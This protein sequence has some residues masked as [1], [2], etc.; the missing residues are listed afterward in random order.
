MAS[1]TACSIEAFDEA[2]GMV[3][4]LA[5]G[6]DGERKAS[7]ATLP[8]ATATAAEAE[9]S[10]AAARR[11]GAERTTAEA[12]R[13]TK[14]RQADEAEMLARAGAEAEERR[15]NERW[16]AESRAR[17]TELDRL[18]EKV[19]RAQKAKAASP[20]P[21][22]PPPGHSTETAAGQPAAAPAA[23]E[24]PVP[25]LPTA[26]PGLPGKPP[27]ARATIVL[28]MK[29]GTRGIRRFE[30]AADPLLCVHGGCY[31]STGAQAPATFEPGRRA[32]GI[33]N[34]WGARAGACNH[35]L[36]CV[37]RNVDL[38]ESGSI[39]QPVDMR[40]VH[41][42]WRERQAVTQDSDCRL[43]GASLECRR[44][45]RTEEYRLWIVAESL[46]EAAGP[47]AIERL[48]AMALAEMR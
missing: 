25:A 15:A 36:G 47:A 24:P 39:V 10:R 6:E 9:R 14:Q 37:F 35:S 48:L 20:A 45:I 5:G 7:P 32:L 29:P 41:H 46:A 12:Q 33:A 11:Q 19:R 26:G 8:P 43:A 31:V 40:L 13:R 17:Q 3:E 22:T 4:R 44:P 18:V 28:V 16:E 42:D 38:A 30:A 27:L 34:T 21:P 1:L 23:A 2:Q